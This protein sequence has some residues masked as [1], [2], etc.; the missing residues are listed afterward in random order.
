MTEDDALK[1]MAA[2]DG[3]N[4]GTETRAAIVE[5]LHR[6]L[7]ESPDDFWEEY[8]TRLDAVVPDATRQLAAKLLISGEV[9]ENTSFGEAKKILNRHYAPK[10]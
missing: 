2:I 4:D 9:D 6:R 8:F 7:L 10:Q 3:Q 5:V 1:A